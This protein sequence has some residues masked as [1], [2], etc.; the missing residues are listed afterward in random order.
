MPATRPQLSL[1]REEDSLEFSEAMERAG[2]FLARRPRS[3]REVR[4]DLVTAGFEAD[5]I[6]RSVAR[7]YELSLLDDVAF[8]AD[9][10]EHR[11]RR[12][13]RGKRAVL[14]E[15]SAKGVAREDAETA[16]GEVAPDEHSQAVKLATAYVR[17]VASKPLAEQARRI[18]DMLARKGF[19]R[20]V[21]AGALREVL[22]PEGWD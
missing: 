22:P 1:L 19:D 12:S 16:W 6:E 18:G 2:R 11:T 8:A 13:G 9:W 4:D 14:A 5:T 15:L 17:R 10:I 7:L 3:E 20:D 21:A